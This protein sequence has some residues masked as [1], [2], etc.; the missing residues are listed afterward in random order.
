MRSGPR[1]PSTR[2]YQGWPCSCNG[3]FK[4]GRLH[5][6]FTVSTNTNERDLYRAFPTGVINFNSM[7]G[8][9][10]AHP[11]SSKVVFVCHSCQNVKAV[12]GCY[13]LFT[14]P[15]LLCSQ[16]LQW[17]LPSE[18]CGPRVVLEPGCLEGKEILQE[19]TLNDLNV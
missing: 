10:K 17:L 3:A 16:G 19:E 8:K 1:L 5:S 13:G 7:K 2:V 4:T 18:K 15:T 14:K 11:E 9:P 12:P 6:Q